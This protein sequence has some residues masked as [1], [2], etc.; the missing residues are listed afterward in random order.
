MM[1]KMREIRELT[2]LNRKEFCEEFDIPYRTVSDWELEKRHAPAYVL[3]LLEYYIRNEKLN[4]N[5]LKD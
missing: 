3:R 1:N 4:K 2:G 5:G